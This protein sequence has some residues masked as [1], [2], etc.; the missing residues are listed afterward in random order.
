[1]RSRDDTELRSSTGAQDSKQVTELLDITHKV[2]AVTVVGVGV[3]ATTRST[4]SLT[5]DTSTSTTPAV[6][7][8]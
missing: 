3:G 6:Q 5:A 2:R 1:M 4:R 7:I 8:S